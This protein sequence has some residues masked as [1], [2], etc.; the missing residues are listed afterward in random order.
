MKRNLSI[1]LATAVLA[2]SAM[3]NGLNLGNTTNNGGKAEADAI[4]AAV[5]LAVSV[6]MQALR[7]ELQQYQSTLAYGGQASVN[8]AAPGKIPVASA[9]AAGLTASGASDT[10]GTCFGSSSGGAQGPGFGVTIGSTWQDDGCD[11]RYDSSALRAQGKPEA[12][13]ARLCMKAEIREAM[14]I[15]GTPCIQDKQQA[16]KAADAGY[17]G[18]DPFVLRRLAQ[19]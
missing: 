8:V 2:T 13:E 12:A 17:T 5:A 6:Q 1:L 18:T 3:A 9:T 15:A 4:A 7:A 11:T 10:N 14:K 19:Q 16:A